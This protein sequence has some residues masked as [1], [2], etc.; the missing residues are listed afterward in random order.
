M[1]STVYSSSLQSV[2]NT[3]NRAENFLDNDKNIR[4]IEIA[5]S[6]ATSIDRVIPDDAK[7]PDKIRKLILKNTLELS[8]NLFNDLFF[9]K[10]QNSPNKRPNKPSDIGILKLLTLLSAVDLCA[11]TSKALNLPNTSTFNPNPNPIPTDPKWKIQKLAF[12]IKTSID[13]YF[14]IYGSTINSASKQ[15]LT[16]LISTILFQL[17]TLTSSSYLGDPQIQKSYPSSRISNNTAKEFISY[18]NKTFSNN[19]PITDSSVNKINE[20]LNLL[21]IACETIIG[22]ESPV[23]LAKLSD[24]VLNTNFNQSLLELDKILTPNSDVIK[25]LRDCLETTKTI[26][27]VCTIILRSLTLAQSIIVILKVIIKVFRIIT[28]FF[29][30]LPIPNIYTTGGITTTLSKGERTISD[31]IVDFTK[32]LSDINDTLKIIS[33]NITGLIMLIDLILPRLNNILEKLESCNRLGNN[34]NELQL[35]NP[36]NQFIQEL[37]NSIKN[38][39]DS[40]TELSKFINNFQNKQ[41]NESD[42]FGGYTIQIKTEQISDI[43]VANNSIPRRFGI[44]LDNN[45]QVVVQSTPTFASDDNIIKNEV[46]LLLSSKGLV[47]Q[48][49][50][51]FD[52]ETLAVLNESSNWLYDDQISVDDIS[53]NN[54]F[55][56]DP[57][58]NEDE[59]SGLGLNAFVNKLSGGKKLRERMKKMMAE[60]RTKLESDLQ[61]TKK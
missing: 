10:K 3:V 42:Y 53:I 14:F 15:N 11:I 24:R 56:L 29:G 33:N 44:A 38:L 51:I 35:N 47:N 48:Q 5:G 9:G 6:I 8:K 7:G 17:D 19:N 61:K 52:P 23:N 40:K 30:V 59:N 22:F 13:S 55:S 21:K 31:K 4:I 50:N 43:E 18:I 60:Q 28:Q 16:R 2:N 58:N 41:S 57:P 37:K 25:V 12:D 20:K 1:S 32:T 27:R 46:K 36:Q 39:N 54:N 45:N 49:S 34:E 26:Q